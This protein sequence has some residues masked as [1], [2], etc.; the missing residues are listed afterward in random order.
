MIM[1]QMEYIQ[2]WQL[3]LE[4]AIILQSNVTVIEKDIQNIK[5]TNYV[6]APIVITKLIY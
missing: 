5:K 1:P 6:P 3:K 2:F 4:K